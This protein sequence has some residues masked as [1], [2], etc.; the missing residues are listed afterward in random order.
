MKTIEVDVAIIGAGSAGLTA[1]RGAL[2]EGKSVLM[3]ESGPYGTTCARVGCMPSKL[4]ISAAE[5]AFHAEHADV[6]GVRSTVVVDGPAVME[7]V[8]KERD[9]FA[10]GVVSSVEE[11][12]ENE[13]LRGHARF[14]S[15]TTLDV[16]GT[17]V[18][19]KA[20]VIATGSSNWI[21]KQ[22]QVLSKTLL[23]S[24][25]IFEIPD[26]P[27]SM[28][29]FGSGV[30]GLELGQAMHRLGVRVVVLDP[31]E[32]LGFLK[33]PEVRESAISILGK[34]F[35]L[36][37]NAEIQSVEETS[38]GAHVIWAT[39]DGVVHEE[40]F[41]KA[42]VA[43]GRRPNLGNLG[44]E[45]TSV[46]LDD[47]GVPKFDPRTMQI[48]DLPIFIAGDANNQKALLHEAADEG[49]IAGSNAALF[50]NVRAGLRRT[51]LTVVFTDPQIAVVGP[52]YSGFEAG[53][54]EEGS[55]DY[56]SQ[57]RARVM[58]QNRGLVK[59][60]GTRRC[61]FLA[62]AEMVGPRVEHTAH[63][64]SWAVQSRMRV[65]QT[66]E[67]PFYHP[68]VEEGIRTALRDLAKA[69][70]MNELPCQGDDLRDGPGT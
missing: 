30:I 12:P 44:L 33:D 65:Q 55:I 41:E 69:L 49:Q 62:G 57:G 35:P 22:L 8:R 23:T 27:K 28:V 21:P 29:V 61:G 17:K 14:L 64:L 42:L 66:L 9:R 53:E 37:L 38:S 54:W 11:I 24:D 26:L 6:F 43:T 4:L 5:A 15:D 16:D 39:K 7:R 45:N 48:A 2:K 47:K 59:I 32:G 19:A 13:K 36:H 58:A 63:L 68:V 56:A 40:T 52:G 60:Y 46:E 31:M 3:I 25:T 10:G 34:E 18:Q 20:V 51:E 67:M 50:P 1:R 70:K